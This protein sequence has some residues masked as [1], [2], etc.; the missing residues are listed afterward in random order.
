M[1]NVDK[2]SRSVS[3]RYIPIPSYREINFVEPKSIE[4]ESMEGQ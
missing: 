4:N 1:I 2:G 3:Y